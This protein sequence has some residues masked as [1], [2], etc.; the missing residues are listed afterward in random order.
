MDEM[1]KLVVKKEMLA[2]APFAESVHLNE[3]KGL[4]QQARTLAV[5][6]PPNGNNDE[7]ETELK[8]AVK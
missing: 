2:H 1:E 5:L 4:Q 7:L 8:E 3:W 6:Q